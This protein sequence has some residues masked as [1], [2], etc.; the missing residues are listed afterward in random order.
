MKLIKASYFALGLIAITSISFA[1]SLEMARKLHDRLASVPPNEATLNQM[2][3]LIDAGRFQDA[4]RIAMANENFYSTT[5]YNFFTPWNNRNSSMD[6]PFNSTTALQIG[7]VRDDVPFNTVLSN[8]LM[9]Y[10]AEFANGQRIWNEQTNP[11]ANPPTGQIRPPFSF[12]NDHWEN[13][14]RLRLQLSDPAFFISNTQS[15]MTASSRTGPDGTRNFVNTPAGVIPADKT[16]GVITTRGFSEEYFSAGTNRRAIR[17]TLINY[18]CVDME[19]VLDTSVSHAFIRR[20]V[21]RSP[22]GDGNLFITKCAGCHAGLDAMAI[23]LNYYDHNSGEFQTGTVQN[24]N[25]VL[26][27]QFRPVDKVNRN[28]Q[29]FP[30]GYVNV[31]DNW[32]NLWVTG[33]NQRLGWRAPASGGSITQGVGAKTLGEVLTATQQFSRCMVERTF[34]KVCAR[35]AFVSEGPRLSTI[36]DQFESVDNYSMKTLFAKVAEVCIGVEE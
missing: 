31:D 33:I 6:A 29:N 25:G 9:Y 15:A 11:D 18:L 26:T 30:A 22:A 35:S 27:R 16:A 8:D 13:G 23:S 2:A 1:G 5:L 32:R 12:R 21:P 36:Q 28:F 3:A 24:I 20:D 17:F 4:A 19:D 34:R 10:F 14:K 7:M